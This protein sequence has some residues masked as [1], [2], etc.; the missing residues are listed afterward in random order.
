MYRKMTAK[1][2]GHIPFRLTS[3]SAEE[4]EEEDTQSIH[5]KHIY[6]IRKR[7]HTVDQL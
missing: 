5:S 6:G 2:T 1:N 4:P 3:A 7:K